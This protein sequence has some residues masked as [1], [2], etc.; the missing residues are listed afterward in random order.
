[1][2]F[3]P[4]RLA[5]CV[6]LASASFAP[7][8]F[9]KDYLI[10][11]ATRDTLELKKGDTLKVT[12]QGSIVAGSDDGVILPKQTSGTTVSVDNAGIIR[13]TVARGIDTKSDGEDESHFVINNRAGALIQGTND[14]LRIQTNPVAGGSL[15][16]VNA[17]T[18]ESTVDGQ[19][20]DLETLNNPKFTTTLT[21]EATGVIHSVGNDA[22]KTGSNAVIT[23]YGL[24]RTDTA[25]QDKD[26]KD[27]KYDGIKIGESTGV[28]V[29]NYGTVSADRHGI[30]L[31]TDATLYNYGAVTGRNGSGFGSDG[32]GTVFNYAGGVITGAIADGKINGDGD[33][34]DIDLIGHIY[35]EGTIQGLGAKGVDSG[36]RPNGSE[37]IAMGGGSI[38][39]TATGVIRS[40]DNGILVDDGAEGAGVAATTISNYGRIEGERGF[41]IKL[42]GDYDDSVTNGGIISG[43]NGL[44]LSMGGGNDHLIVTTGG[45][46]NGL[47]DGGAGIDTLTLDGSG[48]FGNSANFEKLVVSGGRW[49]LSS[50]NDFSQ[51]G[52]VT[53]GATLVNQGSILGALVVDA[54]GVYAGGGSVGGLTVNGS[55]QTNKGLGVATVKGDLNFGSGA[56]LVYGVNADG[57]SAP[58]SVG[59]TARLN[60]ATLHV[61][62]SAGDYPWKSHYTVLNAGAVQGTFGKVESDYAFLT[63]SLSYSGTSVGLDY[64]RNDVSFAQYTQNA[65]SGAAARALGSLGSDSALYNAL[66]NTSTATAGNAIEQL[67]ASSTA[68]L[69]GATLAGSAQVGGSMLGAM[70]SMGSTAG[71][72]VGLDEQDTPVLAATGLPQG[73]RD[74]NDPSARGRLW[75]QALGSYGKVDGSHGGSALEQRTGGLVLGLDWAV[76]SDWRLG[77]LGGY[78]R[79]R[80]DATGLDGKVNSWHAGVYALRQSGPLALRL[81]AA[82]SAHDGDSKR[83]LDFSGFNERIKGDYD[84]D[85]QQA[86]AELGYALGSGRFNAE[87]FANLGYQR[88]HRDGYREK[89]GNAALAVDADTQDNLTSTFGVRIAHLGQLDNGMSLTPRASLGWRHTYGSLDTRTRQ[90]FLAGGDAFSVEGSALDRD[91]LVVEAG[92]TLGVS[93]RQSVGL[94]YSGELGSNSRNHALMGQWELKF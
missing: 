2:L 82:Y 81:G 8:G 53:A 23:N 39:N 76:G 46:F 62:P 31:K 79:T 29:Y 17:G 64:T 60:G 5:L 59:G 72:L 1:M 48:S 90:A 18:I 12:A 50:Q 56:S 66:L 22:I 84:A 88:Y 45:V 11:S 89:G 78:S 85:S 55:L 33:G 63:P 9:A 28:T 43:G 67:S 44:A 54:G 19:A 73:V 20:I 58:I 91:S 74:L 35:N 75:T 80:L 32:S 69:A 38:V 6:A 68:N 65:N 47:V 77:V 27:Q 24:I 15:K 86:F 34:V 42:I 41:A 30:D 87:P 36:G 40:V 7:S 37:G 92:L 14:G 3:T 10:S 4:H 21:N 49:T 52:S 61:Q 71:L 83:S 94:G 25:P 26:G 16:I 51:G 13:S 70:Q 93:A 57:S